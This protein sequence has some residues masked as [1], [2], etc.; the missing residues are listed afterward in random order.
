MAGLLSPSSASQALL[1][2][3]LGALLAPLRQ[4]AGEIGS[5]TAEG[6][7]LAVEHGSGTVTARATVFFPRLRANTA[8]LNAAHRCIAQQ[9]RRGRSVGPAGEW[10]LDNVH[11][12]TAQT[13]EVH[14]GLPRRYYRGLPVLRE[15]HAA[16]LPRVYGLAWAY[17]TAT[18]SAFD[19]ATLLAFLD[20]YQQ[21]QT[22]RHGELWALPTT[23]RVVLIENLRRL[24]E[25]VA[26]EESAREAADALCDRLGLVEGLGVAA[27]PRGRAGARAGSGVDSDPSPDT[28]RLDPGPLFERMEA[29]GVG[30]AFALQVMLRLH[31]DP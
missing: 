3:A 7:R 1:D 17:V 16:G 27:A 19:D 18:D 5:C 22:L 28:A 13:R 10:L 12:L 2:P 14:D 23:L 6:R 20:G 24:A 8:M 30:A 4:R 11:V 29:R 25:R 31:A 15:G 9:G 26:T 21:V